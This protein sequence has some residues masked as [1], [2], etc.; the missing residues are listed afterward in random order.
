MPVFRLSGEP[1]FERPGRESGLFLFLLDHA[2]QLEAVMLTVIWLSLVF[3]LVLLGYDL[4]VIRKSLCD[5]VESLRNIE[6][7]LSSK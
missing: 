2:C 4:R 3:G 7:A 5:I 1:S 6:R